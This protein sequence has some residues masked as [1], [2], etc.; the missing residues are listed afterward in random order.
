VRALLMDGPAP[1][2]GQRS[3]ARGSSVVRKVVVAVSGL[4]LMGWC[5]LHLLGTL[6]VFAGPAV[7][8]RYA[9][10]LRQGASVPLWCLR[11]GLL[12]AFGVHVWLVLRLWARARRA[13]PI[14]SA[15]RGA[16]A[17]SAG[18]RWLRWGSLLLLLAIVG[19]VAHLSFGVGHAGFDTRHAYSSLVSGVDSGWIAGAYVAFAALF[20]LH[21]THG[22]RA[23][24]ISLGGVLGERG[25]RWTACGVGLTLGLG[26][27]LIP[28]AIAL[29][30]VP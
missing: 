1:V 19:H 21:I 11:A 4:L 8:D 25:R 24:L 23:A 7:M 6:T 15:A 18:A 10:W 22:V 26:F 20:G 13:R 30:V 12:A 2:A 28:L 27:A 29:G 17:A 3:H 14:A 9:G 16:N 5:C